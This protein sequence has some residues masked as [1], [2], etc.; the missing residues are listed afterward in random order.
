MGSITDF[1]NF[2]EVVKEDSTTWVL[3]DTFGFPLNNFFVSSLTAT[4]YMHSRN[5]IP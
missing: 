5:R 4:D 1:L 2:Q 3:S